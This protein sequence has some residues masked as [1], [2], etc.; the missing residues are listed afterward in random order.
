MLAKK[1]RLPIEKFVLQRALIKKSPFFNIKIFTTILPYS[2]F[3]IVISKKVAPKATERNRLKRIIFS[4]TNP[5][6]GTPRDVLII[7]QPQISKLT[8]KNVIIEEFN[9]VLS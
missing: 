8:E 3:G 7:V 6:G 1:Y 4:Q 9:K 5:K 2:R